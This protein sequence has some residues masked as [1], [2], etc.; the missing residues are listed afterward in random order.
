MSVKQPEDQ[1]ENLE[2]DAKKAQILEKWRRITERIERTDWFRDLGVPLPDRPPNQLFTAFNTYR[3]DPLSPEIVRFMKHFT[4][5]NWH[6]RTDLKNFL[7]SKQAKAFFSSLYPWASQKANAAQTRHLNPTLGLMNGDPDFAGRRTPL[8]AHDYIES[9]LECLERGDVDNPE[10]TQHKLLTSWPD[11]PFNRAT[12]NKIIDLIKF[13]KQWY[14][15][16]TK[17]NAEEIL[18]GDIASLIREM[19]L[20]LETFGRH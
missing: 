4:V 3:A 8:P 6:G 13:A 17:A 5:Y 11:L 2:R 18:D 1:D 7:E 16:N 20:Y 9:V 12:R 10:V 15:L 14:E 19:E